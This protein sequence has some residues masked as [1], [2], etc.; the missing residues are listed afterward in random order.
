MGGETQIEKWLNSLKPLVRH[1]VTRTKADV[2]VRFWPSVDKL[3]PVPAH[4]PEI[5][6]C[7]V[8]TA[9][10]NLS[11][12][13]H[14]QIRQKMFMAHRQSWELTIG[15]IPPGAH[16]LHR[17]DNPSCVRPSHLFLGTPAV[18]SDDKIQK[19]RDYHPAGSKHP[20]AKLTEE[21][22]VT[23]RSLV[24]DGIPR[25]DVAKQFGFSKAT[26]QHVVSGRSW[27]HVPIHKDVS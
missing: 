23:I 4:V 22:V 2:A 3:G 15:P 20:N 19:G 14:I 7:W 6:R 1:S 8:W 21:I 10:K 18:N 26:I 5:E 17:C 16:V 24:A 25:K 9:G 11:H 13:G 12:Y 27:R